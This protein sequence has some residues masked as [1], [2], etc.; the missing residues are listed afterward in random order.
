MP[1]GL[2]EFTELGLATSVEFLDMYRRGNR[3]VLS[4]L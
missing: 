2:I 1:D 4:P 3:I